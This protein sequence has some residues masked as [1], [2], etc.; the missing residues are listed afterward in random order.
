VVCLGRKVLS[1]WVRIF[2]V[3]APDSNIRGQASAGIVK[4]TLDSG[5][6]V[7]RNFALRARFRG[8]DDL[9]I[10]VAR[11]IGKQRLTGRFG[12]FAERERVG[13]V[14]DADGE[15]APAL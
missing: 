10:L 1:E 14:I 6:A 7:P 2:V 13:R 5:L 9:G 12:H 11:Q 3:P 15:R 8:N 4:M